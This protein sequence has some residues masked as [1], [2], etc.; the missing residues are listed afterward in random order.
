M[1]NQATQFA[2]KLAS[3]LLQGFRIFL[4]F[5]LPSEGSLDLSRAR[6]IAVLCEI[7]RLNDWAFL[8][9]KLG[10]ICKLSRQ[11]IEERLLK[12]VLKAVQ[13][14]IDDM[15]LDFDAFSYRRLIKDNATFTR[16]VDYFCDVV[17]KFQALRQYYASTLDAKP[18]H[19]L[20]SFEQSEPVYAISR[21]KAGGEWGLSKVG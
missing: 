15:G 10:E 6:L 8:P 16:T 5:P 21:L 19:Q 7:H 9:M 20:A 2:K 11:D 12:S 3:R 18:G 17:E 1:S 13:K 4:S 14:E